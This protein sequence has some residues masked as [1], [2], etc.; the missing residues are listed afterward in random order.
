MMKKGVMAILLLITLNWFPFGLASTGDVLEEEVYLL[1]RER[2]LLAFS[3]VG[4]RWVTQNLISRERVLKSTFDGHVAVAVTNLRVLGFSALTNRWSEER[5]EV[6]ELVV[7]VEAEGNVG[8][9]ITNL[10][11]F[12]F[13]AKTGTWTVKRFGL[14]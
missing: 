2:E 8:V 12:G 10:R 3:A 11:A 5:L 9:A 4:N 14:K 6:G 1:V 13:S 7:T